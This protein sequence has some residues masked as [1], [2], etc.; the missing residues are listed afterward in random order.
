[1]PIQIGLLYFS[2]HMIDSNRKVS[3]FLFGVIERVLIPFELQHI[4]YNPFWFQFGE[5]INKTGQLVI[6]DQSIFFA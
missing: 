3:A 2:N 1:M 4:W 5:Y 6:G